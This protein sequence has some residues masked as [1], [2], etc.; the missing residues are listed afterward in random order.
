LRSR[1]LPNLAKVPSVVVT[2]EA[3]Y[4]S[5]YDHCTVKF[6]TQ[7]GVPVT[8]LRLEKQEIRANGHMQ[9]LETNSSEVAAAIQRWLVKSGIG[10]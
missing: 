2:G 10:S 3:S 9:M 4:R 6:L 7:A 5:T 8:H 1:K